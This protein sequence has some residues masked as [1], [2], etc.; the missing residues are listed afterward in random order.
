[1]SAAIFAAVGWAVER[2]LNKAFEKKNKGKK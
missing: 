2:T 1:M